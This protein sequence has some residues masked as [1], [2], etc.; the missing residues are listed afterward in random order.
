MKRLIYPIGVQEFSEI[1]TKGMVY[2]DKT[3]LV[4]ELARH[5]KY[6]FLNRPR[7]FGKSLL[8]STFESYFRG[9]RELFRGLELS[10]LEKDWAQY[11]V[12]RFDLGRA[13]YGSAEQLRNEISL[14][15]LDYEQVYG[16]REAET[17]LNQR[18]TGIIRRAFEKTGRQVV[19]LIDEYDSPLL[20]VVDSQAFSA[21]QDV[22]RNF[23]SP[24]KSCDRL[25]RF[26]FITGITK[27]SQ[28]SIFS[29]LNNLKIIGMNPDYHDICGITDKELREQLGEGVQTFAESNGISVEETLARLRSNYD[30]Y[31]FCQN[32][33]GLYNPFSLLSA[34]DDRAINAY[35]FSTGTPTA[36]TK[37]LRRF[38]VPADRLVGKWLASSRFNAPTQEATSPTPFL[39][40]SGYLTIKEYD[41]EKDL[42]FLDLPNREV[43]VGFW[44]ALVP[45][46]LNAE[47][48]EESPTA[49]ANI[50][51]R[52][53]A[54]D[55]DGALR[56]IQEFLETIPYAR[57]TNTEGHYQT[58]LYVIFKLLGKFADLE[59]RTARGRVDVV[60]Y[61]A[62]NV[63]VIEVKLDGSVEE[64]MAQIE[65]KGYAG[66][67][68][69]LG[70][71]IVKVGVNFSS[72]KRTIDGWMVV[73]P[74][75]W[76]VEAP[77]SSP[78]AAK[79]D[80]TL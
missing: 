25:L 24:L 64:A 13:H 39:F 26:V 4:H 74:V 34:L 66:R 57:G 32:S 65:E 60:I 9:E 49:A 50:W 3:R 53:A 10:K 47:G 56:C 20:D 61:T 23:Y 69:L 17:E 42:Y 15:L 78:S 44:D 37:M 14:M 18:L 35:W 63:Y 45:F 67:F 71:N 43:S 72:E 33:D 52:I 70:R 8:V 12:L 48:S 7:R 27:F 54:D 1:I 28:V 21:M 29:E 77:I 59:V 75:S 30:G 6:V 38:S 79:G 5:S 19:V 31:H 41:A 68:A 80:S 2:V 16:V 46:Y 62:K 58:V 11:P 55:M 22:L 73:R 40:Q 36:L 76:E 51:G